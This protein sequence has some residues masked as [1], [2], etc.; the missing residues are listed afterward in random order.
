M[1][2]ETNN[3]SLKEKLT[4]PSLKRKLNLTHTGKVDLHNHTHIYILH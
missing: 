2:M 4:C 3:S 1:I